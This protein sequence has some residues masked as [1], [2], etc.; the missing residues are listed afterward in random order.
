MRRREWRG[1]GR[2]GGMRRNE[3]RRKEGGGEGV[4]KWIAEE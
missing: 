1:K 2:K 4:V 3:N